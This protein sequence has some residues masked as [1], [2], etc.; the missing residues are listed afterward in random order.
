[1]GRST[2]FITGHNFLCKHEA[3]TNPQYDGSK[4]CRFYG[5]DKESS[6]HIIA[7]CDS[8]WQLSTDIFGGDRLEQHKPNWSSQQLCRFLEDHHIAR[9][10]VDLG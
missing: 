4:L 5:S 7:E 9:L 6:D 10:K 3:A 8:L 1:M 2:R